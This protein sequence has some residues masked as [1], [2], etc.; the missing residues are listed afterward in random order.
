MGLIARIAWRN[1]RKRP[2]QAVF[3]L[4]VMCLSTTAV[5]LGL[6][7]NETGNEPWQRLHD[8]INGY[9][10][11][12]F[13]AYHTPEELNSERLPIPDPANVSHAENQLAGLAGETDVT[14]ASGPWPLLLTTGRVGG[15]K[16]PINVEVRDPKPAAISHPLVVSG[17]WLDDS[18]DVVVLEDGLASLLNVAPGD[19]IT[20]EGQRLRVLGSAMTTSVPR[21]PMQ[22]PATVWANQATAAKLR[23]A[24]AI[25]LGATLELRLARAQDAAPFVAQHAQT[26]NRPNLM[27]TWERAKSRAGAQDMPAVVLTL[28]AL[29]LAGLTVATAA[30]LV[31]GRMAAQ[32]RQIGV[33]K[34]VGVTPRQAACVVLVEYLAVAVIAAAIGILAGTLLSPLIGRDLPILYGAPVAPPITWPRALAALAVALAVVVAGS[35][36]PVVRGMRH[37]TVRA[38]ASGVHVPRRSS[39]AARMAALAGVPLP[40]VLGLRTALR[41][42]VRTVAT[43][44]GLALGVAMV[45]VGLGVSKM[46]RDYLASPARDEEAL[47]RTV[48][49]IQADQ[50]L[51]IVFTGAGLLLVL[52]ALN[53]MITAIFATRDSARNHAILRAVGA[54]P[55]Q[56][57]T[58]FV[59]AQFGAS[60]LGCA[61]GIPL[62][63]F[64]FNTVIGRN[65]KDLTTITLPWSAYVAVA[66]GAQLLYLL[67]AIVPAARLARRRVA[68]VVVY[69]YHG[70]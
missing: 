44:I 7:I 19:E 65:V 9:H 5:S 47:V 48:I 39:R 6:A 59:V 41:R 33:L 10:V 51:T 46:V 70:P 20:L 31:T 67:A 69:E 49:A 2:T 38:L 12:A 56:T 42:P 32:G 1:L 50:V 11:Q 16:M 24:G 23:T 61:A 25:P 34:A 18:D 15:L 66:V 28:F 27:Q 57:V 36:P 40:I 4:L 52:A 22:S 30:V 64:L 37:S 62:G 14:A 29:L 45:I 8:S 63:A 53:A 26:Y 68:P 21:Y 54:T 3:L 13:A 58:S 17:Q 60:L 55:L 35:V 43:A